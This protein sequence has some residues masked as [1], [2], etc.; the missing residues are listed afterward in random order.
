M[1][2]RREAPIIPWRAVSLAPGCLD[3]IDR[4][5]V[6]ARKDGVQVTLIF[7]LLQPIKPNQ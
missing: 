1:L 5:F 2:L 3:Q 7:S 6:K 4:L